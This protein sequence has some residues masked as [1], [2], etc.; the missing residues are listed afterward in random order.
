MK[1]A[2]RNFGPIT[3]TYLPLVGEVKNQKKFVQDLKVVNK[4]KKLL[5]LSHIQ[6][7]KKLKYLIAMYEINKKIQSVKI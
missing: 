2:I 5:L 3:I 4:K 6:S 1:L 7:I